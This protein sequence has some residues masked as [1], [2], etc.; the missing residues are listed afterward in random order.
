MSAAIE[1]QLE[2]IVNQN[3]KII[4]MLDTQQSKRMFPAK[5]AAEYIGISYHTM[6]GKYKNLIPHITRNGR[7]FFKKVDL[8][9][10]L[11]NQPDQVTGQDPS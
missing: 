3:T 7:L 9:S 2:K 6:M 11:L 8:D 4:E 5:K 10:F 1:R